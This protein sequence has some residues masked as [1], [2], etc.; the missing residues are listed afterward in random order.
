MVF[1]PLFASWISGC[2]HHLISPW[3]SNPVLFWTHP[4]L[5]F[6]YQGCCSAR[7]P[8]SK[9]PLPLARTSPFVCS[10]HTHL[11]P[12]P[13]PSVSSLLFKPDGEPPLLTSLLWPP[14]GPGTKAQPLTTP[15]ALYSPLSS[16]LQ[17]FRLSSVRAPSCR[18]AFAQA[19]LHLIHLPLSLLL[20]WTPVHL[21]GSS[22]PQES[23]PRPPWLIAL[24]HGFLCALYIYLCDY[25]INQKLYFHEIRNCD[26]FC[27]SFEFPTPSKVRAQ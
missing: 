7:P 13:S 14:P 10:T 26:Y 20:W 4:L 9:L 24:T 1:C 23:F 25:L 6:H 8:W 27:S 12:G 16:R 2:H 17:P 21:S 5:H 22:F 3:V 15:R 11:C 18:R 19:V